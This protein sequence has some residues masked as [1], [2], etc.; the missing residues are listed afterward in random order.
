MLV[1]VVV[2]ETC[3]MLVHMEVCDDIV[4]GMVDIVAVDHDS[5]IDF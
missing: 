5:L 4:M 2:E 1:L 3:M